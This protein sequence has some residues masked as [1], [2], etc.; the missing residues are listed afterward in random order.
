MHNC[1]RCGERLRRVHR[2][3]VERINYRAIYQC[4]SCQAEET[5]PRRWRHHLGPET[6]CPEC[7]TERITRLKSPDRIDPMHTGFLNFL[8]RVMHG[9]LYHCRLCR[10]QF[11]D[12]RGGATT[13]AEEASAGSSARGQSGS[14][15]ERIF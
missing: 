9:K 5:V 1:P 10:I 13:A 12:R 7:G 11:Y 6:R 4:K 8:E 15:K 2:T 3:F 14:S